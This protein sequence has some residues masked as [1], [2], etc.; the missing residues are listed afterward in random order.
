M[1]QGA[2]SSVPCV[3]GCGFWGSPATNGMCSKCHKEALVRSQEDGLSAAAA[4]AATAASG[5]ATPASAAVP[6]SASPLS[7][8]STPAAPATTASPAPPADGEGGGADSASASASASAAAGDGEGNETPS[9]P[10]QKNRKRCFKCRKKVG[11]TGFR[12]RC[13][14]VF[15]GLH[16]Y[17]DAHECDFD[18][19]AHDRDILS[20][21]NQKVTADKL[22]RL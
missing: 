2:P 21:A 10:V 14:Y 8:A 12:C 13:D 11:L 15:C 22:D 9:R 1:S 17:A 4:A 16:R 7:S 20:K 5:P 19:V 6:S 3:G 18:Y